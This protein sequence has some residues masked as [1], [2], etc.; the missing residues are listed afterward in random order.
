MSEASLPLDLRGTGELGLGRAKRADR[1]GRA[2]QDMAS[3]V[4][5]VEVPDICAVA[6][7]YLAFPPAS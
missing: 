7:R 5:M 3:M 2:R 6:R 1:A 4:M